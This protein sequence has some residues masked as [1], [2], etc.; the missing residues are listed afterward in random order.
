MRDGAQGLMRLL[1]HIVGLYA[2]LARDK[3]DTAATAV[4]MRIIEAGFCQ[5]LCH[6]LLSSCARGAVS[7]PCLIILNDQRLNLLEIFSE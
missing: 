1:Q 4:I 2:V 5:L 6:V 3:T 7:D